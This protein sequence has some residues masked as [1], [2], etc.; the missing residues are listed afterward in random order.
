MFDS[1]V[2]TL[3]NDMLC[4]AIELTVGELLKLEASILKYIGKIWEAL[5][6][7][8]TLLIPSERYP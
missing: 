1:A 8:Q 2:H 7:P 5:R 4:V 3:S 6:G